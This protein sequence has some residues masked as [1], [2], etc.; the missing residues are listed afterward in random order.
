M[1]NAQNRIPGLHWMIMSYRCRIA[2]E[3]S[4]VFRKVSIQSGKPYRRSLAFRLAIFLACAVIVVGL[5]STAKPSLAQGKKSA[6]ASEKE[7]GDTRVAR[8]KYLV[9]GV[10]RC[11][12]CHTPLDS[13]GNPDR[14]RWLQGAPIVWLSP[15]H[16]VNWP[17][18]APRIGGTPPAP[19]ADMIKLLM[20]GIWTTG[21]RLR[22]PMPQF[23][24]NIDDAE[25]I[26]AYLKSVKSE[27]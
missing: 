17:L 20:T 4:S 16:D 18:N 12:Q 22:S 2:K 3:G 21:A 7:G 1:R 8:G 24:M 27:Q 6:G 11:G 26:V 14:S 19:D 23:R 15:T 13:D 5:I 25:A 9:E 10:A